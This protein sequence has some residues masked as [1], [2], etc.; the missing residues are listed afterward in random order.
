MRVDIDNH[1]RI[2]RCREIRVAAGSEL[3]LDGGLMI[4]DRFGAHAQPL[5]LWN[6]KAVLEERQRQ[7]HR[8]SQ[9]TPA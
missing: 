2:E 1:L 6:V 9:V 7:K 3:L 5:L 8:T 4:G